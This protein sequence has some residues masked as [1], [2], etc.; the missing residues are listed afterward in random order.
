MGG[1]G[2]SLRAGVTENPVRLTRSVKDALTT[3][4]LRR[5]AG[6]RLAGRRHHLHGRR[7]AHAG[8]R[9]RLRA[10]AGAGRA[11]R[12]HPAGW[13]TTQRS[14]ATWTRCGRSRR[15]LDDAERRP[16]LRRTKVAHM[17]ASR[18]RYA[19]LPD[20]RRLHLQDGPIDLIVEAFGR[21]DEVRAAYAAAAS[22]FAACSTSSAP[23]C[24]CS[25]RRSARRAR[26]SRSPPTSLMLRCSA[27]R[28]L[29]RTAKR[30]TSASSS[31]LRGRPDCVGPA[32]QMRMWNTTV[33]S[34]RP[35]RAAY[36]RGGAAVR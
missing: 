5:R 7:D 18:R 10:D 8:E 3:R 23:S 27:K 17:S 34:Q 24:R 30:D 25:A 26:R 16:S 32:P 28:S 6:L 12:V 21:A 1:A 36:V 22:R 35:H 19:F 11:D 20:G 31:L 9:L 13:T 29:E 33:P 14:A 2:G 15:S 4:H